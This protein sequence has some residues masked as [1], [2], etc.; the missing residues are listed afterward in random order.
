MT[1]RYPD[2][3]GSLAGI[4]YMEHSFRHVNV[5]ATLIAKTSTPNLE[6]HLFSAMC[7]LLGKNKGKLER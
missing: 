2:A 4:P 3:S 5:I 6:I 1:V 7:L